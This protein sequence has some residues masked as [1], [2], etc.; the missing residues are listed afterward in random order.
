M[1]VYFLGPNI[2]CQKICQTYFLQEPIK[3]ILTWNFESV[4]ILRAQMFEGLKLL[5]NNKNYLGQNYTYGG[6]NLSTQKKNAKKEA[7]E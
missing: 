6:I 7:T 1:Y 5:K 3:K 4:E 2:V